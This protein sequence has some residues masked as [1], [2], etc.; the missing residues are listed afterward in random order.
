MFNVPTQSILTHF[1]TYCLSLL[2]VSFFSSFSHAQNWMI[3]PLDQANTQTQNA[4]C[5]DGQIT[6]AQKPVASTCYAVNH[7]NVLAS[8]QEKRAGLAFDND[9]HSFWSSKNEACYLGIDLGTDQ[10]I[11]AIAWDGYTFGETFPIKFEIQVSDQSTGNQYKRIKHITLT[12]PSGKYVFRDGIIQGNIDSYDVML[13]F[14]TTT[15]RR[16]RMLIHQTSMHHPARIARMEIFS[17]SENQQAQAILKFS[18]KSVTQW[19]KLR[20]KGRHIQQ[21][22]WRILTAKQTRWTRWQVLSNNDLDFL[23]KLNATQLELQITLQNKGKTHA[24]LQDV[25]VLMDGTIASN[26]TPLVPIN[27]S[28]VATST[29]TFLWQPAP[30]ASFAQQTSYQLQVSSTPDFAAEHVQKMTVRNTDHATLDQKLPLKIGQIGYWRVRNSHDE[31]FSKVNA[32]TMTALPKFINN[33]DSQGMNMGLDW[34]SWGT[35]LAKDAGFDWSR[36]DISWYR[37]NKKPGQWDWTRLDQRMQVARDAQISVL[38][39]LGYT[40]KFLAKNPPQKRPHAA[41]PKRL[42]DWVDYVTRATERYRDDVAA[43][44]IWN[45]QN[46][47]AF[48]DGTPVEYAQLLK[49]AYITIKN[50]S[51]KSLVSFGGHAGF[52]EHYLDEVARHIGHDYWDF[53]NWHC[54]PNMPD[55]FYFQQWIDRVLSYQRQRNLDKPIWLTENGYARGHVKDRTEDQIASTIVAHMVAS[56]QTYPGASPNRIAKLFTFQLIEGHGYGKPQQ[57]AMVVDHANPDEEPTRL[58]VFNA[59]KFAVSQLR[60]A[61]WTSKE[62]KKTHT[63]HRF[64]SKDINWPNM[65]VIWGK[66]A[67]DQASK[68]TSEMRIICSGEMKIVDLYGKDIPSQSSSRYRLKIDQP[69]YIY[70]SRRCVVQP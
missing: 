51:P 35:Q 8:D 30:N 19:Q 2:L 65:Q 33:R 40:P 1:C 9:P 7:N 24:V 45:E 18:P 54:Y 5:T 14:P 21:T 26:P 23:N 47:R 55:G 25:R 4:I 15:A 41:P 68:L 34:R 70:S 59:Y 64:K 49:S 69:Y 32:F 43:W 61:T 39:I 60:N 36:L 67:K 3:H 31:T 13:Q 16:I 58:P 57:W 52:A 27:Q 44:E 12:G 46:H 11:N 38:G 63:I 48:F 62:K 22:Q 53:L 50:I 66:A 10:P 37:V 29:P 6:V 28:M 56:K 42:G 17:P 20:V